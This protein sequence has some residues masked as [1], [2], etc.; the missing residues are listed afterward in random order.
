MIWIAFKSGNISGAW[1]STRRNVTSKVKL[2]NQLSLMK[3]LNWRFNISKRYLLKKK[4][5]ILI[6]REHLE[7]KTMEIT[8]HGKMNANFVMELQKE[9]NVCDRAAKK[10]R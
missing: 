9:L 7:R 10:S 1:N 3:Q 6:L 2:R 5:F 8:R 4:R